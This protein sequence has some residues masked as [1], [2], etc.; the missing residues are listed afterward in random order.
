MYSLCQCSG[1]LPQ[2]TCK[3]TFNRLAFHCFLFTPRLRPGPFL[4]GLTFIL[5]FIIIIIYSIE[6]VWLIL[7]GKGQTHTYESSID[8]A[9]IENA[10]RAEEFLPPLLS[11]QHFFPMLKAI[12]VMRD[13]PHHLLFQTGHLVFERLN[14]CQ[15]EWKLVK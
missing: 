15:S 9:L 2:F 6:G 13:L 4:L 11:S 8:D 3:L 14:I 7:K 5:R 10:Y 1:A 12:W